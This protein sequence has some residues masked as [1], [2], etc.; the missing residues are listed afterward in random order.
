MSIEIEHT[1][2]DLFTEKAVEGFVTADGQRVMLDRDEVA[3]L[4]GAAVRPAE[5]LAG[6]G[7]PENPSE[8]LLGQ[9]GAAPGGFAAGVRAAQGVFEAMWGDPDWDGQCS[10]GFAATFDQST[11]DLLLDLPRV[12]WATPEHA[13]GKPVFDG[14]GGAW[15]C[16]G[17]FEHWGSH[18]NVWPT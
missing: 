16:A 14:L 10:A 18:S 12:T 1:V 6:P 5:P 2:F 8:A 17:P 7:T 9:P 13:C 3:A 11:C 15:P 4:L